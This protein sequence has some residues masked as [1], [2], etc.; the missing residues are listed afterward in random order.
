MLSYYYYVSAIVTFINYLHVDKIALILFVSE[1]C[2]HSL[3][4]T[5]CLIYRDIFIY[6]CVWVCVCVFR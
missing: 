3:I 5:K 6:I 4:M 1:N 2:Y